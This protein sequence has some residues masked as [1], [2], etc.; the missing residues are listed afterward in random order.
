MDRKEIPVLFSVFTIH[1]RSSSALTIEDRMPLLFTH[2]P[3]RPID[4]EARFDLHRRSSI[5]PRIREVHLHNNPACAACGSQKDL[6]CHHI[7]PFHTHPEL[8]L[9]PSNLLTLCEGKTCNCHLT[10]GHLGLWR[11]WNVNIVEDAARMLA[12][13][14]GRP[15]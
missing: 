7:K 3:E 1:S 4:P 9:S 2:K 8:E 15:Q 5:W 11:S 6:E 12:K 10:F 14:K 13:I